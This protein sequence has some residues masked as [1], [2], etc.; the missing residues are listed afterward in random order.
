M[1]ATT[2]S[3]RPFAV[4]AL[5]AAA[6][7]SLLAGC[8]QP[9]YVS[10]R[11]SYEIDGQ[12]LT[13][14]LLHRAS[15]GAHL[16]EQ[17]QLCPVLVGA[18]DAD[19]QRITVDEGE[20]LAAC[21]RYDGSGA[22]LASEPGCF[23]LSPGAGT[24]T[25]TGQA[26]SAEGAQAIAPDTLAVDV[27][28][29]D[30]VAVEYDDASVRWLYRD[31]QPGPGHT[32]P[33]APTP[34]PDGRWYVVAGESV[35]MVPQPIGVADPTQRLGFTDGTVRVEG[36]D[37]PS[38]ETGDDGITRMVPRAGEPFALALEL[39]A[40]TLVGP[41]IVPV[42]GATATSLELVVGWSDCDDP[43]CEPQP[44]LL[45]PIVR[46]GQ[47]HRLHGAD[48]HYTLDGAGV[49]DDDDGLPGDGALLDQLCSDGTAGT[50]VRLGVRAQYRGLQATADLEFRCPEVPLTP[51]LDL[52][53]ACRSDRG[54]AGAAGVLLV[55]A[56]L[57]LRRRRQPA[58]TNRRSR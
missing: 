10:E 26:C 5:A 47:G 40:G 23:A 34:E 45:Q 30:D 32:L 3:R 20:D 39:P 57:W 8:D 51:D 28:A 52:D 56:L 18:V 12:G 38:L 46:D 53:C 33:P 16:V 17:S 44:L 41:P 1:H 29:F 15:D 7:A 14:E 43:D 48:V 22:L 58:G 36:P 31:L 13:L 27:H 25:I 49:V 50:D 24:L 11:G 55:P 42:D 35:G 6:I 54:T 37:A 2:S 9:M 4:P 21:A 19:G